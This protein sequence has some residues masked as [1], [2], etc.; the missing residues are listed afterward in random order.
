MFV[1]EVCVLADNDFSFKLVPIF[2]EI[3]YLKLSLKNID[4]LTSCFN[5]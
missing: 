4:P 5:P 1:G 2:D 3:F